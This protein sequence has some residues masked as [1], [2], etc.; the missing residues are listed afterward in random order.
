MHAVST[1]DGFMY[2]NEAANTFG[3]EFHF[4][5][6]CVAGVWT[7][8]SNCFGIP[9]GTGLDM[10]IDIEP[11]QIAPVITC[12]N[13]V[14]IECG[15]PTDPGATGMATATDDCDSDPFITYSDNEILP[16]QCPTTSVIMRT[17]SAFDECNNAATCVQ[18]IVIV[19]TTP[20]DLSCPPDVSLECGENTDPYLCNQVG[21]WTINMFDSFG[22]GWDGAS[23]TVSGSQADDGVYTVAGA[24]A[25]VSV[26][27]AQGD[28]VDITYATGSFESEHSYEILDPCGNVV[29]SDGPSPQAGLAYTMIGID[30]NPALIAPFATDNCDDAP[31]VTFMDLITPGNCPQEFTITR[32]WTAIDDCGNNTSCVQ[33]ITVE[34]TAPPQMTCTKPAPFV[35]MDMEITSTYLI[36]QGYA[37][38]WD[39]CDPNPAVQV[40]DSSDITFGCSTTRTYTF[41]A[42][43]ACGNQADTCSIIVQFLFDDTAPTLTCSS[44]P[45]LGCNPVVPTAMDLVT[46]GY[47]TAIDDCGPASIGMIPPL[48]TFRDGCDTVVI[49]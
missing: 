38:A 5:N 13:D 10:V 36:Q 25:T 39:A 4:F 16:Q 15:N 34:D 3:Q 47:V 6:N 24:S 27:V 40:V 42:T 31:D 9:A 45:H 8:S 11:D 1:P 49:Y 48:Q 21:S 14:T 30:V 20:P 23:I 12:P 26:G 22:D 2:L 28:E 19:D 41:T 44:P 46:Q 17:W 29:F 33:T 35:C 43:D 18:T 7:P 32:T 37:H